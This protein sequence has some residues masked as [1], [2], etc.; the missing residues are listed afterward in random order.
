MA[1]M[2]AS[3]NQVEGIDRRENCEKVVATAR[4]GGRDRVGCNVLRRGE[5]DRKVREWLAT[6]AP[7]EGFI[8]FAVGRTAFGIRWWSGE[9]KRSHAKPR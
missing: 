6:A 7:V 8:G 3:W 9:T 1:Q 4:R 2:V 5:D